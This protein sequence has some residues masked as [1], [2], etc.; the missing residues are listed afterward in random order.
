M[1]LELTRADHAGMAFATAVMIY[2]GRGRDRYMKLG[3]RSVRCRTLV[4]PLSASANSFSISPGDL[5]LYSSYSSS[6]VVRVISSDLT[7]GPHSRRILAASAVIPVT[8]R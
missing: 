1:G 4:R 6:S 2:L 3:L 5:L 8:E 7:D